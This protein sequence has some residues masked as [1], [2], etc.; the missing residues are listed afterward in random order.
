MHLRVG[1]TEIYLEIGLRDNV[2]PATPIIEV[3]NMLNDSRFVDDLADSNEDA[4]KL[5]FNL[6]EYISVCSQFGFTHG[7]VSMS[8]NLFEGCEQNQLRTL[9]GLTWNPK[10]DK[11]SPNTE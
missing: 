7:D 6:K 10:E 8:Y 4:D 5:I 11:W 9:L 3:K 1:P 2:A